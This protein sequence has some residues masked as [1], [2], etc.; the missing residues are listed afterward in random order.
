MNWKYAIINMIHVIYN[1]MWSQETFCVFD[2]L[3]PPTPQKKCSRYG[4]GLALNW[5]QYFCISSRCI[6]SYR[7]VQQHE[8][9]T[10]SGWSTQMHLKPITEALHIHTH[11]HT[12]DRVCIG[13]KARTCWVMEVACLV[14]VWVILMGV[15]LKHFHTTQSCQR[16]HTHKHRKTKLWKQVICRNVPCAWKKKKKTDL[17]FKTSSTHSKAKQHFGTHVC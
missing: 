9:V 8:T 12:C 15:S 14:M 6:K 11:T 17:I 7:P 4:Y 5:N 10:V 3:E 1:W 16:P 2:I 13:G